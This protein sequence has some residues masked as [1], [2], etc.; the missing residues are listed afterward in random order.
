MEYGKLL[1][2][3]AHVELMDDNPG[4]AQKRLEMAVVVAE[5]FGF[6]RD[7]ALRIEIEK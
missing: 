2:R 7:S 3:W 1:C 4:E 5:E 6:D